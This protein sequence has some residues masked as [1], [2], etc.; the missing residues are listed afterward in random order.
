MC[1]A[2]NL[3]KKKKL[4]CIQFR[5]SSRGRECSQTLGEN[6]IITGIQP[7]HRGVFLCLWNL[8][9][10][11]RLPGFS[12]TFCLTSA[13]L[14]GS[15]S[16]AYGILGILWYKV[17]YSCI[18]PANSFRGPK[19][20]MTIAQQ[21]HFSS[22]ME[23]LRNGKDNVYRDPKAGLGIQLMPQNKWHKQKQQEHPCNVAVSIK[24]PFKS[25]P[26]SENHCQGGRTS[27]HAEKQ[28]ASALNCTLPLL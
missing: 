11:G 8:S 26:R 20:C 3:W 24:D 23:S 12:W 6:V 7:I 13:Y 9:S 22:D 16:S 2:W 15:L 21:K 25:F 14:N 28:T 19:N 10:W 4:V 5:S 17:S 18:P 1:I 27:H